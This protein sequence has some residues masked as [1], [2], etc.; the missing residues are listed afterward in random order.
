MMYFTTAIFFPNCPSA[1][2]TGFFISQL[3][4]PHLV[5]FFSTRDLLAIP[6]SL[7]LLLK[8]EIYNLKCSLASET[9]MLS[10]GVGVCETK[11]SLFV[12]LVLVSAGVGGL[13]TGAQ[14]VIL[15]PKWVGG[16]DS[17]KMGDGV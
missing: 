8:A 10:G 16:Y 5:F 3:L 1:K 15:R 11:L 9:Q 17:S 14:E 6:R 12:D 4:T 2:V 13:W 7:L